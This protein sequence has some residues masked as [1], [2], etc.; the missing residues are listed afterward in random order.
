MLTVSRK[1]LLVQ[2]AAL[3]GGATAIGAVDRAEADTGTLLTY[4]LDNLGGDH[5]AGCVS[6]G[7]CAKHAAHKYFASI[8]DAELDRAH[9]YCKCR[10]VEGPE[11][12]YAIWVA[13]FGVP[14]S[15][16]RGSVDSRTPWVAELLASTPPPPAE[17]HHAP[18]HVRVLR[19]RIN[20][21]LIEIDLKLTAPAR[22]QVVMTTSSG[23]EIGRRWLKAP[24]GISR[25]G[26]RIPNGAPAGLC[27]LHFI[28]HPA[29]GS[30]PTRTFTRRINV[31]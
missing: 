2:A 10:V 8:A 26:L 19:A 22:I 15:I 16:A 20:R 23:R 7:A 9:P 28:A 24:K 29:S 5:T 1:H 21:R 3:V 14:G 13:L 30:G 25:K 11:F 31:P 27:E 18:L 6:C 17:I 4:R 12:P